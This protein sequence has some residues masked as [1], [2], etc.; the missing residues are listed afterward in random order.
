LLTRVAA[1]ERKQACI[2]QLADPS[3]GQAVL[4]DRDA[5]IQERNLGL[6]AAETMRATLRS[7]E[8]LEAILDDEDTIEPVRR[9][10][11]RQL[12]ELYDYEKNNSRQVRNSAQKPS[13]Q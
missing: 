9:E 13:A 5:R 12:I 1:S 7:Q 2:M 11:E 3:S 8:Q 4:L 10:A 6:D